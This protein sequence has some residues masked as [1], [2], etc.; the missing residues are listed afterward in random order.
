MD[1]LQHDRLPTWEGWTLTGRFKIRGEFTLVKRAGGIYGPILEGRKKRNLV[2][3]E[4][5]AGD[6]YLLAYGVASPGN[7]SG[8]SYG[9]YY[10]SHLDLPATSQMVL[11]NGGTPPSSSDV[12]LA[13]TTRAYEVSDPNGDNAH[14]YQIP[15]YVDANN[16]F[17]NEY[18]SLGG[19]GIDKHLSIDRTT[20]PYRQLRLIK[21]W[22]SQ[23]EAGYTATNNSIDTDTNIQECGLFGPLYTGGARRIRKSGGIP[24]EYGTTFGVIRVVGSIGTSPFDII[25]DYKIYRVVAMFEL[26]TY[27]DLDIPIMWAQDP[28]PGTD[29]GFRLRKSNIVSINGADF[30]N[31]TFMIF[32]NRYTSSTVVTPGVPMFARTTFTP[33][34][35]GP[36]N[37]LT[38]SWLLT[39]KDV[40]E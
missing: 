18:L 13:G 22:P 6:R 23:A 16:Y 31:R 32:F 38:G 28:A 25:A 15:G 9:G 37:A 12:N 1:S 11:G 19:H 8:A 24:S 10:N 40:N 34:S 2:G 26:P 33:I 39:I 17:G 4:G 14:M 3:K 35:K 7:Y 5:E 29:W 30:S 21:H 27:A 36:T 20:A